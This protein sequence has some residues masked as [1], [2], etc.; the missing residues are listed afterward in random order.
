MAI[1][2]IKM[3]K[4]LLDKKMKKTDLIPMANISTTTLARLSKDKAVSM[5]VMTRI[6]KALSCDIGD[7]MEVLPD[8]EDS[9]DTN[10]S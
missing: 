9:N 5:E 4:L 10:G 7:I 1:S 8:N 6:C 3:W 2:Y